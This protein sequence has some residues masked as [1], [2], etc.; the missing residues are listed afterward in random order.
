MVCLLETGA[1]SRGADC[2]LTLEGRGVAT[3]LLPDTTTPLAARRVEVE[4]RLSFGLILAL[5]V[6][7]ASSSTSLTVNNSSKSTMDGSYFMASSRAFFTF[8]CRFLQTSKSDCS[9]ETSTED[10]LQPPRNSRANDLAS[11]ISWAVMS[12]TRFFFFLLTLF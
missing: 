5:A 7:I 4:L 3:S 9:D 12:T 8:F 6:D 11:E 1:V 10:W 2:I